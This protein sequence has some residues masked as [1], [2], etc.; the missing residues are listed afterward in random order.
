[1]YPKHKFGGDIGYSQ[2]Q[3][4]FSE[5]WVTHFE[6]HANYHVHGAPDILAGNKVEVGKAN[7]WM[8]E[9]QGTKLEV[10]K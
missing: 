8:R 3:S 10:R 1:M 7:A 4:V 6:F 5:G 9:L 2:L